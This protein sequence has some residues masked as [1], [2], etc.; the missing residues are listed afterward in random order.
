MCLIVDTN[1]AH[2]VFGAVESAF[3]TP[4]WS[5]LSRRGVL[6][7]GGKLASE[8]AKNGDARRLLVELNRRGNALLQRKD[9]V[10]AEEAVVHETGLC[11][12]NDHHVIA[13]ARLTGARVLV[14]ED[15][16][17]ME[18]FRNR[19][20]VQPVGKIYRRASHRH[21]LSH[22]RICRRPTE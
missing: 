18:D 14:T 8:L 2:R 17:L 1:Q 19:L 6:V 10:A 22:N 20:L 11:T 3:S 9:I 4:I 21:L 5:W 15:R 16:A 13:L 12:S 7:Y